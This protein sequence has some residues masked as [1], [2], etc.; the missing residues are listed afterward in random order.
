MDYEERQRFYKKL[1]KS[2]E[3]I[4]VTNIPSDNWL[5]CLKCGK[6]MKPHKNGVFVVAIRH[7]QFAD[8]DVWKCEEC[9]FKVALSS[10][11]MGY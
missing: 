1:L 3:S 8:S 5:F 6:P 7:D 2:E 4:K 10:K 9:G 11:R